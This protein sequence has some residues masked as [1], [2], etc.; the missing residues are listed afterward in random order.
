MARK[1]GPLSPA[2]VA[3]PPR[4]VPRRLPKGINALPPAVVLVS[5]MARLVEATA[6]VVGDKGYADTTV[7]DI[8]ARAGVS[9][10]TFYQLF[11]DKE[12]CFLSCFEQLSTAHAQ[13][14]E[15]SL[16]EPGEPP[17]RLMRALSVWLQRLDADQAYAK[18]FI[19][20]AQAATPRI[21]Q[22]FMGAR[23]HLGL[24]LR[25]WLDQ[26]RSEHPE[27]PA[28]TEAG[29]ELMLTGLTGYVVMQVR[30]GQP[31]APQT[32]DI[33]AFIFA[34]LG[35]PRWAQSPQ[36]GTSQETSPI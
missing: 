19:G 17:Q 29:F 24:R 31:L 4:Q 30:A 13:A 34:A 14:M 36:G 25:E 32:Q 10:T 26:A 5:Q 22:A 16:A 33:A 28:P 1:S 8:I 20:E 11:K 12:A 18:A 21:Q 2:P 3:V 6:R 23:Q 27:V 35:V 15:S 9:R 7:A